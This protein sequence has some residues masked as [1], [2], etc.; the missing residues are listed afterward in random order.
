MKELIINADDFGLSSGSN[1]AIIKAWREGILTSASLMVTGDAFAE[2]VTLARENP[3]LQVGLHLTLVQGRAALSHGGMPALTDRQGDFPNDPVLAGMRYFFLKSLRRQ[4][5]AE[6]EGQIE[7]FRETGLPLSHIDGHLNIHMHPTVFDILQPL[8]ARYGITTFRLSR[9]RLAADLSLARRR[10]VGKAADAFI[11]GR[12]A[13]RCRPELDLRRIGYAA[14][15]KGLLNSG[16]MTEAYLLKALD[17]LREGVTEIY[18][19]PG[20]HPDETLRRW[21]P[22]YRH[23]EEL[24]A[25]TSPRVREKLWGL[26]IVLRNYRGDR[27]NAECGVRNAE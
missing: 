26:G 4:L 14:E 17:R 25:L 16:Q 1:R 18:F 8:M 7:R 15:V 22:D 10:L 27:K 6:I 23:E 21:M 2:A 12:L 3:G 20:C 9:E 24:A 5:K 11:F 13:A 19:H